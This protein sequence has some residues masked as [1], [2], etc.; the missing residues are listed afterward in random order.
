MPARVKTLTIALT[1]GLAA[2]GGGLASGGEP[3]GIMTGF[4]ILIGFPS[5]EGATDEGVLLVPGTVI[6]VGG[7]E[8][9]AAALRSVVERSLAF[10]AAVDRLW[11]TFRLDPGRHPSRLGRLTHRRCR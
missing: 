8:A 11:S 1:L 7:G 5:A 4:S 9:D 2:S 6:P 10:T 3:P